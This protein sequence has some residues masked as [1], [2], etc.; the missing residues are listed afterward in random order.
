MPKLPHE[1]ADSDL[2]FRRP[3]HDANVAKAAQI[4]K[5]IS[6]AN[7]I[8]ANNSI[9][10]PQKAQIT[11]AI[12][13]LIDSDPPD[14]DDMPSTS[15]SA[16]NAHKPPNLFLDDDD[17]ENENENDFIFSSNK[18]SKDEKTQQ[19]TLGGTKINSINL[20]A[21]EDGNESDNFDSFLP[22]TSEAPVTI[23][24]SNQRKSEPVR[25][26]F[27]NDEDDDDDELFLPAASKTDSQRSTIL[28]DAPKKDVFQYNL[29]DDKPPDDDFESISSS[30]K[31]N[32]FAED[33]NDDDDDIFEKLITPS[34]SKKQPIKEDYRHE[35]DFEAESNEQKIVTT[36]QQKP[37]S[38]SISNK[39]NLFNP[40][41]LFD[42]TPPSDDDDNQLFSGMSRKKDD[43]TNDKPQP[44]DAVVKK[45]TKEFYN[46]FSET[47]TAVSQADKMVETPE[48][49]EAPKPTNIPEKNDSISKVSKKTP[50]LIEDK[51]KQEQKP[52][53]AFKSDG[54]NDTDDASIGNKRSEF[55]KRIDAF[56][57][58]TVNESKSEAD[59]P[60]PKARQPKKLNIGSI[61]INVAALLPGAKRAKSVDKT[62]NKDHSDDIS[63]SDDT[64]AASQT[65]TSIT[66]TISQDNI[67]SSGRLVNLN[68][69]RAKN[70][71][72]RP[73]TRAGRQQQYRNS[74]DSEEIDGI[75][76]LIENEIV[77]PPAIDNTEKSR[78]PIKAPAKSP[79]SKVIFEDEDMFE[80]S[81]PAESTQEPS[82]IPS[83][84]PIEN[85][86]QIASAV[87]KEEENPNT[88]SFLDDEENDENEEFLYTKPKSSSEYT[89]TA[90][91]PV[92]ATPAFIDDLPPDLDSIEDKPYDSKSAK[93]TSLSQNALSLFGDEDDDDDDFDNDEIFNY[94]ADQPPGV[95]LLENGQNTAVPKPNIR[96]P[97]TDL[98]SDTTPPSSVEK[99]QQQPVSSALSLFDDDDP[100]NDRLDDDDIFGTK[101]IP[102]PRP[103]SNIKGTA[104]SPPTNSGVAKK[105]FDSSIFGDFDD[106]PPIDT[107]SRN[108]IVSNVEETKQ[109]P[110][111]PTVDKNLPASSVLGLFDDDDDADEA[112]LFGAKFVPKSTSNAPK[113]QAEKEKPQQSKPAAASSAAAKTKSLFGDQ[114]DDDDDGD[115][116]FGGPPP[117]PEPIKQ[118]QPKKVSQKI[119]SD[120]SSDDDLFGGGGGGAAKTAAPRNPP[121]SSAGR[122]TSTTLA[123]PKSTKTNEKL[124]SDSE[125]DDLFGGS[126]SKPTGS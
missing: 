13:T 56:S 37:T 107:T 18:Q 79:I 81:A 94:R 5:R 80:E 61:D 54:N 48:A 43:V 34:S 36:E 123:M 28:S 125:D 90:V 42:D 50:P 88:F 66:K 63:S 91:P 121:K 95:Y 109:R 32:L 30:A 104:E 19:R 75:S 31:V 4:P 126:K 53:S 22:T 99:Q 119:F 84:S 21:D 64:S 55:M 70:L 39:Q 118:A 103:I 57:N 67:D 6:D 77:Q 62:D 46:D 115:D 41:G 117:L 87:V 113:G 71:S 38:S 24:R 44:V 93:G 51:P 49:M 27:D 65:T 96:F 110:K 74:M 12:P 9:F 86:E 100:N 122:S 45:S 52:V 97:I 17:D 16:R 23:A 83:S 108:S 1:I 82:R 114:S 105:H 92:K 60:V 10:M 26:L 101:T 59:V 85:T 106:D 2:T 78:S 89:S 76:N 40:R 8:S 112:D 69:N 72:R 47:I 20:F 11:H 3:S 7:E 33:D 58:T 116:L 120:D 124:F 14:L 25:N 35:I 29:F 15:A 98:P 73:S 102:A 111:S 68:R